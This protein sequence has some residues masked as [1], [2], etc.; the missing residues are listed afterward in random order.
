MPDNSGLILAT[1]M[2]A[3]RT[4]SFAS[5]TACLYTFRCPG[6]NA[7]N[8]DAVAL[9]PIDSKCGV[10]A[11]A[12][13]LGGSPA[14][15]EAA[16]LALT[17][18]KNALVKGSDARDLRIPILDAIEDANR[19]LQEQGLGSATTLV[20]LE[21][22]DARVRPYHVGD[23]GIWILGGGGRIKYQSIPHSPVGYGIE[24]GVLDEAQ[25]IE[26]EDRDV[27]SNMV[28]HP[29]MRIEVGP[30][31]ELAQR[32]SVLLAS[33]GLFDNLF[34]DEI[35]EIVR[36]GPIDD[37]TRTL[38]QEAVERMSSPQKGQPSKADDLALIVYRP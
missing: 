20:V 35:I 32:D 21:I 38:A 27:V 30:A 9:L 2:E 29:S 11:V 6:N 28:G 10:L 25:A 7:V 24:A 12:D 34:S 37:V 23:S 13:G 15:E 17:S 5:G 33:D 22:R 18:L 16:A 31:I 8:E 1:D 19:K 4:E 36:K 26:H 3:P 14:G